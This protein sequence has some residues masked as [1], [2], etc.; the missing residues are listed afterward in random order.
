MFQSLYYAIK[1]LIPRR[2]QISLR[3]ALIQKKRKKYAHV[4]PIDERAGKAPEGW[5]GWPEGK[6]FAVVLTHDVETAKGVSRCLPLADLEERLGFRSLFNFVAEDYVI[7]PELLD[8]LKSRGFEVGLHG[9]THDGNMFKSGKFFRKKVDRINGYLKEWGASGFRSPSMYRNLEYIGE[10]NIEYDASSFDTDP[11]EPQPDGVGTIFPFW[12][13][14]TR[15]VQPETRNS[16][17]FVELPYTMPQ[18]FNLFVI[19]KEKGIDIWRRKLDWIAD[20]GGMALVITHPDYINFNNDEC[21]YDEYSVKYYEEMLKYIREKYQGQCWNAL[22]KDISRLWIK[23]YLN[24]TE[25]KGLPKS[26]VAGKKIWIDLD[27]SPHVPFFHPIIKELGNLGFEVVLTARN[28]FQTCGLADLFGMKYEMIGKHYGK[29]KLLK[30]AGTLMRVLQLI[31]VVKGRGLSL[32]LSHGSRAQAIAA[33]LLGVPSMVIIDYEYTKGAIAPTWLMIPEVIP[34]G[35]FKKYQKA[36]FKYPG[37][38]EDVYISDLKP[39]ANIFKELDIDKDKI[40]VTIRPPATEAHY[41]N[42][43]SEILF[44]EVI[45]FLGGNPDVQMVILPRNEIKQTQWIV[46]KWKKWVDERKII[47]PEKVVNGLNLLWYSDLVISGGGTMNRE[48]A[49]LRVPVYSIFRGK[50]GAVDKYLN[51]EGR[52][53]LLGNCDDIRSK[54]IIVRRDKGINSGSK[55]NETLKTIIDRIVDVTEVN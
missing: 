38:K 34:N 54:I 33:R 7:P 25:E 53:T 36:I 28:C 29:N 14:A 41:H 24:R 50:I 5:T 15:K 3:R 23:S 42:P 30:V 1:P 44:Q 10:L 45:D 4:W 11:F 37:I 19:M 47:I 9:L 32:A 2:L 18:D 16:S 52:L 40:L 55:N 17:G 12:V 46:S 39:D 13:P 20:K 6:K 43:E 26:A 35:S 49:A 51:Q 27:N 22:P 21:G 8:K 48:A 31:R